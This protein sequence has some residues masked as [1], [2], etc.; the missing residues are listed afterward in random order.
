MKQRPIFAAA[1]AVVLTSSILA[2][3]SGGK[4]EQQAANAGSSGNTDTKQEAPKSNKPVKLDVIETGSGLPAPDQDQIKQEIDKAIG[5]EL[6][7]TVY[8]SGDDYKNQLNVRMA[9]GNFPDLFAVDRA[10]LKQFAEQGLLLDLTPYKDKLK[11]TVD[12]IGADSLKKGTQNGKL[13]AIA[14]SPQIPYN[15]FWIRKDWLDKLGMKPPTTPDELLEVAKA[16]TEKDPDGNGKKDTY[17]ITGG[18]LGAFSPVFG[19]YG[20]GSPGNFYVKDGKLV[21]ALY[22]PAMKDALAFIK[23]MIDAG[24]VDPEL[25][26]NNSTQQ[27]QQKGIKGQ[28]GIMW[29][30]WPNVT[31]DEFVAQIKAVNPNA[32]WIQL[33]ALKGPGGQFEGSWDIGATPGMY[34]IPKVLEKNPEKLNKVIE[35]L[36]FVSTKD[37]GSALVQFGIKGKHYN[38][39]NGKV[40][41]TDLMGK[42]VGYSWLYQFTGRPEMEYLFVKFAKQAP[43]IEFAN[44]QPRIQALNGFV[45][46]PTGYNSADAQRFMDEE[47]A[48]FV[49]GKRPLTEYDA[50]LKTLE[51]SMNYK[52]YLDAATK[53]LNDL[54]FGK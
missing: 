26:S 13:Y 23:K 43:Y 48:K 5:T 14:K 22:D 24:A 40:M 2:G 52:A 7:L 34:A 9:S 16:F 54:G 38:L 33:P 35:L 30:D 31:K 37:T 49:Y 46:N 21:N 28:A 50:F 25:L 45:D 29:I 19:A 51:T 11:T 3:C 27:Y 6:N 17:G 44:K 1:A 39:E 8:A 10:Q 41:P 36:N 53:Q 20:T 42:E 12:F 4:T 32:D 18:K 15:T 47:L